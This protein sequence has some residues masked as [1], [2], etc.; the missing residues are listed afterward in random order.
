MFRA[1]SSSAAPSARSPRAPGLVRPTRPPSRGPVP[2]AARSILLAGVDVAP[3]DVDAALVAL[4]TITARLRVHGD[5]RAVFPSVY[6]VITRR[7]AEAIRAGGVF[8]EPAWIARLAGRFGER[9]FDALVPSLVGGAPAS[10]A[11]RIAFAAGAQSARVPVRDA[12]LGINAHINYDLA[13]GIAD[14]VAA[15]GHTWD[16]AALARYKHDHDAVNEILR[17]A[18]PEI[19]DLLLARYRCPVTWLATR[20]RR[21]NRL[22]SDAMLGVIAGWRE[23]VWADMLVLLRGSPAARAARLAEMDRR[24]ARIARAIAL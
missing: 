16:E 9:Y 18:L 2:A 21:A 5:P 6:A 12:L 22:L 17:A 3:N 19:Y 10:R 11:W 14:N 8:L 23:D 15:H 7:V 24:S 13:Q 4:D 1:A 20:S